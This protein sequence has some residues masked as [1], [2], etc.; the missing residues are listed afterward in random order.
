[1]TKTLIQSLAWAVALQLSFYGDK[2]TLSGCQK[3]LIFFLIMDVIAW[4]I[5]AI[6][7]AVKES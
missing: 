6:I 1:M 5:A 3:L 7:E 2:A 4:L